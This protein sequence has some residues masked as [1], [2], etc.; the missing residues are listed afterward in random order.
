M[1]VV[2]T[3]THTSIKHAMIIFAS[4][5]YKECEYFQNVK[6]I[7]WVQTHAKTHASTNVGTHASTRISTKVCTNVDTHGSPD[8]T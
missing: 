5:H 4:M 6:L 7:S 3:S 1:W 2:S 8:V